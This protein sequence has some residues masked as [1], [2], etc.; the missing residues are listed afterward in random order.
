MD[1][2]ETSGALEVRVNA[3]D[4]LGVLLL[5]GAVKDVRDSLTEL[6]TAGSGF[7]GRALESSGGDARLDLAEDGSTL[8]VARVEVLDRR[9][10]RTSKHLADAP[11][12]TGVLQLT[13]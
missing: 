12:G 3:H 2:G 9:F 13:P 10:T 5:G 8:G 7:L 4:L 11:V 1:D 6:S